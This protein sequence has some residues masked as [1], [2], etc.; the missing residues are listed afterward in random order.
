MFR[1][2][3]AVALIAAA[4]AFAQTPDPGPILEGARL[5]ATLQQTDLHGNL[6]KNGARTPVHLFLRG[7]DIQFAFDQG[8]ATRRFHLRLGDGK[9]DLFDVSDDGKTT[10]FPESKLTQSIAGSDVTYEDLAFRFF[11]WPSPKYEGQED[12]AG[13]PC[14]KIRLNKPKGDAGRYEVVYIWI[15]VKYGA[16]MCV[17]GYNK[18]GGL[19]KEFQVED[20]MKVS[21]GVWTLRKMQISSHNPASGDRTGITT[22]LFDAPK[23]AGPKGLR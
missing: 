10:R 6:S 12:V 4:N 13:Q 9:Y 22:L 1:R 2:L 11:Y 8:G 19:V 23:A 20:I 5:A 14:H 18:A 17:R 16:F 7:K 15:H 21:D 3:L